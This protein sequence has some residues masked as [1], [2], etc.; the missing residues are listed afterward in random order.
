MAEL[1]IRVV[2]DPVTGRQV[3]R[4]S[5]ASDEDALPHEHEQNHRALVRG[6]SP[7]LDQD[8]LTDERLEVE[9]ERPAVEPALG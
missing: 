1:T 8:D 4:V 6:L 3:I 9:R 7:G 2:S 5:L